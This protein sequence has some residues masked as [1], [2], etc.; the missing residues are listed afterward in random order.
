MWIEMFIK[1]SSLKY[2]ELILVFNSSLKHMK[3]IVNIFDGKKNNA[4]PTFQRVVFQINRPF[5]FWLSCCSSISEE[6]NLKQFIMF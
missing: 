5:I 3:P 6:G 4:I 1:F 2:G